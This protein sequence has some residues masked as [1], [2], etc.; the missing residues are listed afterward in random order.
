MSLDNALA[1]RFTGSDL[2][3]LLVA[4]KGERVAVS[5]YPWING[6]TEDAIAASLARGRTEPRPAPAASARRGFGPLVNGALRR[7]LGVELRR[8]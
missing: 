6:I 1:F 4:T 5:A 3:R 2:V 8:I 7:T